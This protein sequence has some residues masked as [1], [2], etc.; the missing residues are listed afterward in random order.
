MGS[1][2]L[3]R[4]SEV[5][6]HAIIPVLEVVRQVLTTVLRLLLC[7]GFLITGGEC[8]KGCPHGQRV[9]GEAASNAGNA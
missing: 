3:A 9:T 7:W 2:L 5:S 6:K 4:L 1:G 8:E